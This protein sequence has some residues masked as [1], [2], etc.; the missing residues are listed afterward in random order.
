MFSGCFLCVQLLFRG[1]IPQGTMTIRCLAAVLAVGFM[2]LKSWGCRV[3][4]G[5]VMWSWGCVGVSSGWSP[6]LFLG[7]YNMESGVGRA[8][9]VVVRLSCKISVSYHV[10]RV[11]TVRLPVHSSSSRFPCLKSAGK[12]RRQAG[13]LIRSSSELRRERV[14]LRLEWNGV[15]LLHSKPETSGQKKHRRVESD[16]PDLRN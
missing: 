13:D 10:F 11:R 8:W 2:H 9:V 5:Q 6:V 3:L 4:L 14:C 7:D 15:P 16:F 1:I 12:E